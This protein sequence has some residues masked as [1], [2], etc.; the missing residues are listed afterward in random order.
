MSRP[1]AAL[2]RLVCLLLVSLGLV[3]L[4]PEAL[5]IFALVLL[6]WVLLFQRDQC[7]LIL[8]RLWRM[9]WFFLAI[10][11]LYGI[12]TP[13]ESVPA[14]WREAIYRVGILAVLVSVVSLCLHQLAAAEL[15]HAIA[16]LLRP[17]SVLG[18]PVEAFARRLSLS[19]ET[20]KLM[21][22]KMRELPRRDHR[23][24]LDAVVQLCLGAERWQ[25]LAVSEQPRLRPAQMLD[26]LMLMVFLSALAGLQWLY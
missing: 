15:A 17:L 23:A 26:V 13:L 5:G 20:V 1:S 16:R 4:K 11:I 10:A 24:A 12:G 21:D 19:L 6:T 22:A 18:L 9:R 14:A 3:T 7:A 2:L 8:Q 25:P